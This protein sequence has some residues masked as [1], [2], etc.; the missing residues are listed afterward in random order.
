MSAKRR[1]RPPKFR[2]ESDLARQ[3]SA[4]TAKILPDGQEWDRK[5][6]EPSQI[7]AADIARV[8]AYICVRSDNW[9]QVNPAR[10]I[11]GIVNSWG[12]ER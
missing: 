1:G 9:G 12:G 8:E 5:M 10:L 6:I 2:P 3:D 4:A 7:T 11:A